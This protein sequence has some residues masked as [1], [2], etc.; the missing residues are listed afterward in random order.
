MAL[1][2]KAMTV[3]YLMASDLTSSSF[4]HAN[5]QRAIMDNSNVTDCHFKTAKIRFASFAKVFKKD[6]QAPKRPGPTEPSF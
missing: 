1:L 2:L 4:H 5:L 6:L 3:G